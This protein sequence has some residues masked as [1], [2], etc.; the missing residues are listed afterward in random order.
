MSYKLSGE[1]RINLIDTIPLDFP[2]TLDFE[3]T[4]KCN[5]KCVFCPIGAEN[6]EEKV[7]YNR[8]SIEL[9]QKVIDEV[10]AKKRKLKLFRFSM[11]G[12][13]L[14]HPDFGDMLKLI[15]TS[16]ISERIEITTNGSVLSDKK[17]INL[18]DNAPDIIRISIYGLNEEEYFKNTQQKGM[19]KKVVDNIQFLSSMK[20]K[21]KLGAP[22]I[23]IKSFE[24]KPDR[25]ELF[26]ALFSEYADEIGYEDGHTWDGRVNATIP[27]NSFSSNVEKKICP[28]P[29]YKGI[30][31]SNGDFTFCC[32]DWE[33]ATSVGNFNN[34]SIEEL[35]NGAAADKFR[36]SIITGNDLPLPC[37]TCNFFQNPFFVKDNIDELTLDRFKSNKNEKV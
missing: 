32:V 21:M 12:E 26:T 13:A 28:F 23:Y 33:R 5:F 18:L 9:L 31:N 19:F 1:K 16:R 8:V 30:I 25:R 34:N 11:F 36:E 14:L 24:T 4:N 22:H 29:F 35:F 17:I 20:K 2:L 10:N 7:G 6:Y 3:I 15:K 27:P 37:S